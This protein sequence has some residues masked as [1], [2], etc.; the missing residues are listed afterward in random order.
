MSI[1]NMLT[2]WGEGLVEKNKHAGFDV[3]IKHPCRRM[4]SIG[5]IIKT[6]ESLKE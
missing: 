3:N 2:A 5:R 6:G 4:T 1:Q